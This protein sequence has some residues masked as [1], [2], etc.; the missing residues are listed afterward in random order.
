MLSDVG[1]DVDCVGA[2]AFVAAWD[3][4]VVSDVDSDEPTL[5][6][7]DE[8]VVAGWVSLDAIDVVDSADAVDAVV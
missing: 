3:E 2:V 4:S 5:A 8:S 7:S 6:V 1:C